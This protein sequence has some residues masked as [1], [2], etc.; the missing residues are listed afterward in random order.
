MFYVIDQNNQVI[1]SETV[2][3]KAGAYPGGTI[4][5]APVDYAL[6]QVLTPEEV[7][8]GINAY[9]SR[10]DDIAR[11]RAA[12]ESIVGV[13]IVDMTLGQ[14]RILLAVMAYRDGFL[15]AS[16]T[17]KPLSEVVLE[18]SQK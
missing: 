18:R 9:N 1:A 15:D 17:V 10:V 2:K 4:I 14:L 11:A 13:N 7:T 12:Y 16:G 8:E 3:P 5:W 6:D